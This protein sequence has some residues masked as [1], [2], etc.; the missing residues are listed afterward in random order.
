MTKKYV[1]KKDMAI[2]REKKT[3][4]IENELEKIVARDGKISAK[5]LVAEASIASHPLHRYFEWDDSKAGPKY[6]LAQATSMI[7]ATR[8]VVLL[9]GAKGDVPT[10]ISATKGQAHQVRKLLPNYDGEGGYAE[11]GAVLG[12]EEARRSIIEK[13]KSALRSWCNSVVDIDELSSIRA[14]IEKLI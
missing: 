2:T 6:R 10:A 8:F 13:K 7:L 11:R 5:G 4:V 12:S 3:E 1:S 9:Q 14:A